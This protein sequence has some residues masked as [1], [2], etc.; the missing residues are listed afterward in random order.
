[1]SYS[2]GLTPS[3]APLWLDRA[4]SEVHKMHKP[5][6]GYASHKPGRRES[7]GGNAGIL[8]RE[9]A[10]GGRSVVRY[11]AKAVSRFACHTKS[12]PARP[13]LTFAQAATGGRLVG[14][15]VWWLGSLVWLEGLW[16]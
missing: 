13:R 9:Q 14:S 8:V 10:L 15:T 4:S 12:I 2:G 1:M 16:V 3:S 11:L 7:W 6:R 5:S